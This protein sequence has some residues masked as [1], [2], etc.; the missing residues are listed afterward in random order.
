MTLEEF[1]LTLSQSSPPDVAPLLK[2]LWHDGKNDWDT[3]HD[4]AQDIHSPDGSWV[5]AYLHRKEGDQGNASYWYG[6]AHRT[7]PTGSLEQEWEE[8]VYELLEKG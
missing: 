3:A 6:R 1:K 2:A 4:L 8:I 5:H 7:M